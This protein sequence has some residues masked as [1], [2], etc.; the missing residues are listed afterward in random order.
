MGN[1]PISRLQKLRNGCIVRK[2]H[3]FYNQSK[4]NVRKIP[5]TTR[6]STPSR[7]RLNREDMLSL[8]FPDISAVQEQIKAES[9]YRKKT[10]EKL[11]QEAEKEWQ[12]A[13]EQFEKELLGE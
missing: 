2:W 12:D 3:N 5:D 9:V 7:Y 11:R 6:G 4:R 10:A 13:R 1:A 8:P